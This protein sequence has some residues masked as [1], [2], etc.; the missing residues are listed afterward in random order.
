MRT[1]I[2]T[3]ILCL[4]AGNAEAQFRSFCFRPAWE[5]ATQSPS[6]DLASRVVTASQAGPGYIGPLPGLRYDK[7]RGA[8][9]ESEPSLPVR[10]VVPVTA[11][12]RRPGDWTFPGELRS[13]LMGPP[14]N[15]PA[16]QINVLSP[17]EVLDL[18][19]SLHESTRTSVPARGSAPFKM[20]RRFQSCPTG[21]S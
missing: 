10:N 3:I 7:A 5:K 4:F 6:P 16:S 9:I 2:L 20:F 17:N 18:H 12:M 8:Y 15:L 19:N 11:S 14:H 13:H 21:G 1:I